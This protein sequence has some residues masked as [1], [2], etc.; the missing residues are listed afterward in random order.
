[1]RQ[2]GAIHLRLSGAFKSLVRDFPRMIAT[3]IA[4]NFVVVTNSAHAQ[5]PPPVANTSTQVFDIPS[6]LLE[7]VLAR[8]A[9]QTGISLTFEP[10][11]VQGKHSDGLHGTFSVSD[12]LHVLLN[13]TGIESQ[14]KTAKGYVL[15]PTSSGLSALDTKQVAPP[16]AKPA[17]FTLPTVTVSADA[18]RDVS[19]FVAESTSAVTRTD[20]PLIDLPQS[21]AIVTPDV[22]K[23]Q[24]SE[25]VDDALRNVSG[26]TILTLAGA[27]GT[28]GGQI[29][30]RGFP[31][32]LVNDGLIS[33]TPDSVLSL[34]VAALSGIE[35]VK[36]AVSNLV[37]TMP[38][39]GVINVTTKRPQADPVH[40]L[41][42][43][44][45]SYGEQLTS[46]DLAG[47]I[48]SDRKLTYRFVVSGERAGQDFLG[49]DGKHDFYIAPS[50][51]YRSGGTNLVVGVQQH[52]FSESLPPYTVLLPTG[53]LA[54]NSPVVNPAG[55]FYGNDT[56]VYYDFSQRLS[57][58]LTFHSK[59]RYDAQGD[60]QPGFY[61]F[62]G[63]IS[64]APLNGVFE[65]L[66]ST[67][68]TH[69]ITTDNNVQVNLRTGSVKQTL[70]L[71]A[72]YSKVTSVQ[73]SIEGDEVVEPIPWTQAPLPANWTV[74]SGDTNNS[75]FASAFY[76]QDQLTWRALDVVAGISRGQ[77]WGVGQPAQSA[78]S[79]SLGLVYR[80]TDSLSAY[81][82]VQR[83]F[84]AQ[85]QYLL[86]SGG[87]APPEMGRSVEAGFK[88]DLSG[89]R[90]VG[91]VAAFRSQEYNAVTNDFEHPGYY[92]VMNSGYASRGF[93]I[94]VTA[95]PLPGW[96]VIA[97][98]TYSDLLGPDIGDVTQLPRHTASLWTTYDLQGTRWQEWG[99]GM[100]I[101][102]RSAYHTVDSAGDVASIPGQAGVDTS[103]YY[104]AL[105][106]S[107]TVGVK[108]VFNRRL[109]ADYASEAFVEIEPTRLFYLTC[110]Y[111]F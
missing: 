17:N 38:P 62:L 78:W 10:A 70:L 96:S 33:A 91:T 61:D 67:T 82:N 45:G 103:L 23:S 16:R 81:A 1:M 8:F 4:L 66:S 88:F 55:R 52:A 102:A 57:D 37:G 20:T 28:L 43:Q 40:E 21:V 59:V 111:D 109:Y 98:Y 89:E 12:A 6:G 68:K 9:A 77:Q 107:A 86:F 31:A 18:V 95:R 53:P 74:S 72:S 36:G 13:G 27:F 90:L 85:Q 34:P 35:V 56:A 7:G 94:D 25:S 63:V 41:T 65:P 101:R 110:T 92:D 75:S 3:G 32:A 42:V 19:G 80:L 97:S 87:N 99:V 29:Y 106:W 64:A 46:L 15:V 24:Q 11:I 73:S 50:I 39:S 22:L 49:Q 104:H 44:T 51:G 2:R 83:S 60:Y 5:A 58:L 71:G 54:I 108:N 100:G 26:V 93:E 30:V 105:D 76:F 14:A 79:P 47:A 48:S 69:Q 84:Y